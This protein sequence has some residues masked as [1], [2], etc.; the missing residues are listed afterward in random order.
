MNIKHFYDKDTAT[1]TYIV[2]D[3]KTNSCA[4]I[5][6]VMSYD[7]FSGKI[8]YDLA[9]QVIEY[10]I[11]NKL[12]L[13]WIL[14]THIHADHL[15]ASQYIKNKIG[16]KIAIG[17]NIKEVIKF[18]GPIFNIEDLDQNGG[19]FDHLFKDKENFQIGNLKVEVIYTPGHTPACVSYV[20]GDSIFVGDT[21]FSPK[22][23]TART[24]FPGG[25][26]AILYDSIYKLFS[27][28]SD[29]KIYIGHDYPE[30]GKDPQPFYSILEQK[31]NNILI[32]ENIS[33]EDY[34][35][36]R[37]KRDVGKAV[38][39][40][41]LPSLQINMRAGKLPKAE[42]NDIQYIKIPLNKI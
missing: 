39:K 18:W 3:D 8:S 40:L 33:K 16:G 20:I 11:S 27:M 13:E 36:T 22:M 31:K 30:E 23:G 34:V 10:I 14:E 28:P 26:A 5:D 24:D 42:D 9:D 29:Y 6:S 19:N 37:N 7:I 38:P 21:I 1:F 35:L 12:N 4:V 41:L 32:N 25:S 15:T 2:S 17:E